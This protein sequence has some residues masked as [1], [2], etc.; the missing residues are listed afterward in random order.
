MKYLFIAF[1]GGIGA[2][3]RYLSSEFIKKILD[4]PFPAGTFTVNAAGS[5]LIGFLFTVFETFSLPE[6]YRLFAIT[7]FLGG[8]TT[9]SSYSLETAQH[10]LNG[11]AKLALAN[12]L[13]SNLVC[14]AFA[15]AGMKLARTL[16]PAP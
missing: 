4:T 1:G 9:F 2:L 12:I 6:E 8:Y 5:L 16:I 3:F 14:I 15:I 10:L 11:N 7:G 13:L